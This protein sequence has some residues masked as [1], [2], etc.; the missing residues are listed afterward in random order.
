MISNPRAAT[1]AV[2]TGAC[3]FAVLIVDPAQDMEGLVLEPL[4]EEPLRLVAALES[5]L[6]GESAN[7]AK[8]ME[9]PYITPV[10]GMVARDLED[11]V[12]RA[13]GVIRR[14]VVMEFGHPEALKRAVRA[15]A[16]V[17]FLLETTVREDIERGTMRLVNTPGLELTM[18]LF[19]VHRRGKVFSQLQRRLIDFIKATSPRGMLHAVRP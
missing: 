11:E 4:W 10:K 8:L 13:H 18:P 7:A 16:G 5:Q 1:E 14:N 15:N 12:L 17:S 9:L 2:R 6:V 19:F 3:D